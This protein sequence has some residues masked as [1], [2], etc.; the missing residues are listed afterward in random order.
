MLAIRLEF[1]LGEFFEDGGIGT[2]TNRMAAVLGIQAADLRV[3]QAYE[4]SVVVVF[5]VFD[6]NDDPAAL[7]TITETFVAAIPTVG[8]LFGGPVMSYDDG[9]VT[10]YMPGYDDSPGNTS[11]I[12]QWFD[13][14]DPT[15]DKEPKIKEVIEV[16]RIYVSAD[17]LEIEHGHLGLNVV[18]LGI[19][20]LVGLVL[21]CLVYV[22]YRTFTKDKR[23]HE[24]IQSKVGR[25]KK[26]IDQ[27]EDSSSFYASQSTIKPQSQ[28]M[29]GQTDEFF[30]KNKKPRESLAHSE[31]DMKNRTATGFGSQSQLESVHQQEHEQTER[32]LTEKEDAQQEGNPKSEVTPG[33]P[34]QTP[35]LA[36]QK[37]GHL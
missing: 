20:V 35:D 24:K 6:P 19:A 2:F 18:V 15:E 1:T 23:T 11:N 3:V 26:N 14:L 10:V 7:S 13:E 4:G 27:L 9:Q 29:P 12:D 5:Q 8:N 36:E 33:L 16:K 21:V 32:Q 31:T 22:L 37:P 25:F 30:Y 34:E 28:Y 17:E